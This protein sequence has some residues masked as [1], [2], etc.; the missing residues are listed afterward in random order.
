MSARY[1]ALAVIAVL[2]TIGGVLVVRRDS[3]PVAQSKETTTADARAA[4]SAVV[5]VVEQ[6]P[7]LV[8]QVLRV[9]D[10]VEKKVPR[11]TFDTSAIV[12]AIG[13]D[14]QKLL[15]WTRDK[16]Y[17]VPYRGAL[18]GFQGVLMDR[19]GNS[20]DRSLLLAELLTRAGHTV[21]LANRSL[22]PSQVS[23]F[24]ELVVAVPEP[25]AGVL[26]VSATSEEA[27]YERLAKM[28]GIGVD[29]LKQSVRSST[30][31]ARYLG[32]TMADRIAVQVPFL[33]KAVAEPPATDDW[34]NKAAV[35]M[36]D[37]WWIQC[38]EGSIWIDLD[39]LVPAARPAGSLGPAEHTFPYTSSNGSVPLESSFV[40]EVS[41]RVVVGQFSSGREA[42]QTALEYTLRPAEVFGQAIAIQ[43]I[44]TEW[45]ERGP[46]GEDV[47]AALSALAL[48]QTEWV[49]ALR[50]GD[51]TVTQ[52]SF[53]DRGDVHNAPGRGGGPVG[54]AFDGFGALGGDVGPTADAQLTAVRIEYEIRVPGESPK[55]IGRD[56]FSLGDTQAGNNRNGGAPSLTE[57]DRLARA[58]R[59][60]DRVEVLFQSCRPSPEY[61][62]QQS[63]SDLSA[64]RGAMAG[65]ASGLASRNV[66]QAIEQ[67]RKVKPTTGRLL[68]LAL[69]RFSW[70]PSGHA[71]YLAAPNV[72]TYRTGFAIRAPG[73][74]VTREGFDIVANGVAVHGDAKASAFVARLGQGVAD[75]NAEAVLMPDLAVNAGTMLGASS[76]RQESWAF[77]RAFED[78]T[79]SAGRWPPEVGVQLK[80]TLES[81]Y[82]VVVPQSVS[83]TS[84]SAPWVWW[85]VDPRTGETLGMGQFGGQSNTERALLFFGTGAVAYVGFEAVCVWNK[86]GREKIKAEDVAKCTCAGA[87]G[88]AAVGGYVGAFTYG[89]KAGPPGFLIGLGFVVA[90]GFVG[91]LCAL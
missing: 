54:G 69:A 28:T 30:E 7:E 49:P 23:D 2:A 71:V 24:L 52:S 22:T 76:T 48:R 64:N 18:R 34:R 67:S 60:L 66:A 56:L 81:G 32:D 78:R 72:L 31:R 59:L 27:E 11:D 47:V 62:M 17:W 77:V 37:H 87:A 70:N 1:T 63:L 50:I 39:P 38:Q 6:R 21:R 8:G 65:W 41:I 80:H 55:K 57:R 79:W 45:P 61:L 20:L 12:E 90:A 51:R 58:L 10:D 82:V 25:V 4:R 42:E 91:A 53:T 35:A 29:V 89:A 83:S 73:T 40:H 75:T 43:N 9:L 16:T 13:R 33:S 44:P 14:P 68:A 5:P 46:A 36:S 84:A 19:M 26:P 88:G 3:E 85:R 86:G 15:E 74:V